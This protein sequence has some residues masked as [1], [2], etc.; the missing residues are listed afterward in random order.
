M[1]HVTIVKKSLFA[2]ATALAAAGLLTVPAPAQVDPMVPTAPVYTQNGPGCPPT[3]PNTQKATVT[4][5][6][7]VYGVPGDDSTIVG[8]LRGGRQVEILR[9]HKPNDWNFVIGDAVPSQ[10][11]WVWGSFL[12]V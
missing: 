7:D 2:T 8:I 5:D 6:V 11:G 10:S 1:S 3:C 4:G 12:R 9:G